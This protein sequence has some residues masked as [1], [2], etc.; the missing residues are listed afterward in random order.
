MPCVW[1]LFPW[2]HNCGFL[3]LELG[4]VKGCAIWISVW[5]RSKVTRQIWRSLRLCI[6]AGQY[7]SVQQSFMEYLCLW[8][9]EGASMW[10]VPTLQCGRTG[11]FSADQQASWWS[12]GCLAWGREAGGRGQ[13]GL[14]LQWGL[15]WVLKD[16]LALEGVGAMEGLSS[17]PLYPRAAPDSTQSHPLQILSLFDCWRKNFFFSVIG[18]FWKYKL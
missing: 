17:W 11:S 8:G 6:L 1:R 15:M 10:P 9:T 2:P 16:R 14:R 4:H 7:C 3:K 13:I 5:A 18:W 12:A